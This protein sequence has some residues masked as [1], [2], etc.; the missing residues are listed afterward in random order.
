VQ[1]IDCTGIIRHA[2]SRV[3][4]AADAK[5]VQLV[6]IFPDVA[7]L[8]E[9]DPH[10]VEQILI[11]LLVNAIRHTP[12]TSTVRVR[13][14]TQN[15]QILFQIEDEGPGVSVDDHERIFDI[16]QTKAEEGKGTGLGLPLSRR[17]ARLLGGELRCIPGEGRGGLFILELPVRRA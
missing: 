5:K 3:T 10:R 1:E 2:I 12:E 8:C 6:A 13:L 4:P 16:Y 15:D 9:T 11:N 17:L 7:P 14:L